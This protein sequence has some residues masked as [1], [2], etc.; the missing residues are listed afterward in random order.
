MTLVIDQSNSGQ[1]EP[2]RF[3][4]YVL[5]SLADCR[6]WQKWI[7]TKTC[8]FFKKGKSNICNLIPIHIFGE[9]IH[10]INLLWKI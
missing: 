6:Y 7:L 3:P 1:I 2:S 10:A 8:W 9:T 5:Q 4:F